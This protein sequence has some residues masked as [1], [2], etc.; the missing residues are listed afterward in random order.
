MGQ[1]KR[2]KVNGKVSKKIR[3]S[4]LLRLISSQYTKVEINKFIERRY[5][6]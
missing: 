4:H 5:K 2:N 6:I 1:A 3:F